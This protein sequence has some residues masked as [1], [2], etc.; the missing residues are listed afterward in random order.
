MFESS[1]A[2]GLES[3]GVEAAFGVEVAL[4]ALFV[5]FLFVAV[6]FCVVFF[7]LLLSAF[8]SLLT[9]LVGLAAL[10]IVGTADFCGLMLLAFFFFV[11]F[12][13]I[14]VAFANFLTGFFFVSLSAVSET[15]TFSGFTGASV[16]AASTSDAGSET[17]V[18]ATMCFAPLAL[19]FG[20]NDMMR[21]PIRQH[22]ASAATLHEAT[23]FFVRLL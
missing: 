13:V 9:V 11:L 3:F 23:S 10:L 16:C 2:T 4:G 14:F 18:F 5:V 21:L 6:L 12:L 20:F 19:S 8:F 17:G 7:L 22:N 15:E 1:T